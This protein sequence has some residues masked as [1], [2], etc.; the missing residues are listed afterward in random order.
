MSAQKASTGAASNVGLNG[1]RL[2][3]LDAVRGYALLLGIVYH[4]TMAYLPGPQLWP[5]ID[6]HRSLLLSGL[7]YVSHIFRMSTFFLI[8]GFFSHMVVEKRGVK[9]WVKDRA[10]R[11]AV[12]LLVGWPIL[13]GLIV[14]ATLLGY[15]VSTGHIPTATEHAAAAAKAPKPPPLAF[16]LTHL[17]FLYI[18]LWLYAAT[19]GLRALVLKLDTGGRLRAGVDAAIAWVVESPFS[20]FILAVPAALV[21]LFG[22]P[23]REWFGVMTPDNSL[24]PNAEAAVAYFTA[25]GFGWLVHRQSGLIGI[26][27][28]RWPLNLALAVASTAASLSIVGV[29][30]LLTLAQ[31]GWATVAN[32]GLY[33]LATWSWTFAVIG[34]ALRFLNRESPARRYVADSSYW[35]YLIHLPLVMAL[36]AA[37]VKLDLPAELKMLIVLAVAFPL[38]FAS[39]HLMVRRTFIG[40]I[41]NGRRVPK[42]GKAAPVAYMEPAE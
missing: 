35:L 6:P 2:H 16:P 24:I 27:A 30:P 14:A 21:F 9:A 10:K 11:I 37:V 31:P 38:M 26:W 28:R 36:Q 34:L 18:L 40:A 1:Q 12:P 22:G 25:F 7:F 29:A 15:V 3:G 17:W 20:A 33:A 13:F 4:A 42:P 41:L 39:Y 23:W 19:L 32:A 8:A 5:V